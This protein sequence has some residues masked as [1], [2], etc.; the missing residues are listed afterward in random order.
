[1][2]QIITFAMLVI[3]ARPDCVMAQSTNDSAM[4]PMNSQIGVDS[5]N[6]NSFTI[7]Y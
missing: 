3:L 2:K 4:K 7:P 1:M 5:K 6:I